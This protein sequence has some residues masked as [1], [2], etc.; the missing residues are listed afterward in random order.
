ME[1]KTENSAVGNVT[2]DPC[3]VQTAE[4]LIRYHAM[5]GMIAKLKNDG[6]LSALDYRKSCTILTRK[7]GFSSCSI[8]SEIA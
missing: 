1:I 5:L 2:A 7:Y 6:I 4:N 3:K 8:F